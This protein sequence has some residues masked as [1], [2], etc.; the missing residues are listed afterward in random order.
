MYSQE[1]ICVTTKRA[2][3]LTLINHK[4]QILD[5]GVHTNALMDSGV[6]C[7]YRSGLCSLAEEAVVLEY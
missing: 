4:D 6:I 3:T 7:F 5:A 2:L 1:T